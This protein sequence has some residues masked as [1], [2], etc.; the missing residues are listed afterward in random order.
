M[1]QIRT[2]PR[3]RAD[4]SLFKT[5]PMTERARLQFRAEAFNVTNHP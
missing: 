1:R 5:F 2:S 3:A 4:L